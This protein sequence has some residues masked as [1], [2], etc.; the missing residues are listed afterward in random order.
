MY[1]S[2]EGIWGARFAWGNNELR[3]K[4]HERIG[5]PL[6]YEGAAIR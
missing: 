3:A 6:G 4:V 2:R 1:K 5:M